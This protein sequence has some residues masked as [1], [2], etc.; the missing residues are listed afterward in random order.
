MKTKFI[1]LLA[2]ILFTC[3]CSNSYL[4]NLNL[5]SLNNMLDKKETFI[6]FLTDESDEGKLLKKKLTT[7]SENNKTTMYFLNTKNLNDADNK[8]LKE[9]FTFEKTNTIIFIKKGNEET[10]LARIDDIYISEEKLENE[11]KVQGY[12]K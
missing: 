8:K 10:V 6:L 4:K 5:K 1:A 7:I 3:A 2:I 12:I 9:L 11:F